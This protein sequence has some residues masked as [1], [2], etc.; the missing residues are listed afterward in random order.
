[1]DLRFWQQMYQT[2]APTNCQL[3]FQIDERTFPIQE[4]WPTRPALAKPHFR[5]QQS[6]RAT[7]TKIKF[8]K[9]KYRSVLTDKHLTELV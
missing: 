8:I 7:Y 2:T 5:W 4:G 9:L 1:M 3:P 6:A